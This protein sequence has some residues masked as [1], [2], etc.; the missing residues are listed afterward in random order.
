[1]AEIIALEPGPISDSVRARLIGRDVVVPTALSHLANSLHAAGIASRVSDDV[2]AD[3]VVVVGRG[4]PL[5]DLAYV[6]DRLLGPGGCPW[7]QAQTHESLKKYLIEEAYEVLDAIDSGDV[8]SFREELGDLLLQPVLHSQ[9][10]KRDGEFDIDDV[11]QGIVDKLV[12]RHPHV[13]GELSVADADEVLRN[14]DAIKKAEKGARPASILGEVPR[15]MPSLARALTIS[16]RA[17]RAG[18][19]WPNIEGVYEK[20]EE[21]LRELRE[22]TATEDEEAMAAEL[23][24]LLFTVVNIARWLSVDPEE[25]L[26]QMVNR[27][28]ARFHRM[29]AASPVPLS[30]LSPDEWDRLWTQ[31]KLLD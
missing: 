27:F 4:G 25:A 1:V 31:A 9:M 14:W 6:T 22:A 24:D 28:V 11:A 15:S 17:A 2:P 7:D 18:F 19:E 5:Y 30:E 23:G 26:R 20:L 8:E 3:A 21:E 29:E 16:K 10:R 12:R 13:F